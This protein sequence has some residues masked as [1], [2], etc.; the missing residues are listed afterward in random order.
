[1]RHPVL[2]GRAHLGQGPLTGE[3]H[4]VVAEASVTPLLVG[5]P[6]LDHAF[7][8]DLVPGGSDQCDH[9]PTDATCSDGLFCNGDE[10]CDAING[11]EAGSPPNCNDGVTCTWFRIR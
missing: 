4:R 11:C 10:T 6:A 2:L 3:E 1:M 8:G 9:A 5:D 7:G